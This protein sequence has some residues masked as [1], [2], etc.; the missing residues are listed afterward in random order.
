MWHVFLLLEVGSIG[1]TVVEAASELGIFENISSLF[2]GSGDEHKNCERSSPIFNGIS[3]SNGMAFRSSINRAK[4]VY[5]DD[6]PL[7]LQLCV[8]YTAQPSGERIVRVHNLELIT[9]SDPSTI[10]RFADCHCLVAFLCK[11]AAYFALH[12]PLSLGKSE[13]QLQGHNQT[14]NSHSPASSHCNSSNNLIAESSGSTTG[15]RG[16]FALTRSRYHSP[17]LFLIDTCLEILYKYRT[18]CSSHSPKRATYPS[19][20][21]KSYA[22]LC[23]GHVKTPFFAQEWSFKLPHEI[24][25]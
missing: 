4:G 1:S 2:K 17:Q 15:N 18:L 6:E 22:A 10:F 12:T 11:K 24:S 20:I 13:S 3:S 8:T 5:N 23:F 19:R 9:S 14:S 16:I 21:I 25:S 7:Y